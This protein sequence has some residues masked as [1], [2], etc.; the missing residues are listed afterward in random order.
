MPIWLYWTG[1]SGSNAG[2]RHGICRDQRTV[3]TNPNLADCID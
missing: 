2:G 1:C 3:A